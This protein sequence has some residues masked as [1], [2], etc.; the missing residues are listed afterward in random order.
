M[1]KSSL[2]IGVFASLIFFS[3]C[4]KQKDNFT[5]VPLSD[6]FPLQTGK[7]ITYDLDSLT[8]VNFGQ[9]PLITHYKVKYYTDSTILDNLGRTAYRIIRYIYDTS[10]NVWT[11]DNTFMAVNTGNTIQWTENNLKFIKLAEPITE[12]FT[13]N[14]NNYIDATSSSS[15]PLFYLYGWTYNYDSINVPLTL[16]G[17]NVDSTIKVNTYSPVNSNSLLAITVSSWENSEYL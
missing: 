8:F 15:D 2:I 4:K 17:L 13:W 1:K 14:G 12:G 3:A 10:S 7:Y 9:T 5:L 16:N 11:P 6:Y